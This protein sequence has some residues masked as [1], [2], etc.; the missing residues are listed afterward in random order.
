METAR[1]RRWRPRLS[2]NKSRDEHEMWPSRSSHT[3]T[4][5]ELRGL[6][7][8]LALLGHRGPRNAILPRKRERI[9]GSE[10]FALEKLRLS[11]GKFFDK[12]NIVSYIYFGKKLERRISANGKRARP[13][14]SKKPQLY[15]TR[16]TRQASAVEAAAVVVATC[17]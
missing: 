5:S 13:T 8:L 16:E 10:V 9:Y 12:P 1:S 15:I 14:K 4:E 11:R 17:R 3:D 6:P 2:R 7:C